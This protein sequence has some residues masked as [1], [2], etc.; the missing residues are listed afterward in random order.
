MCNT[1][2]RYT[3]CVKRSLTLSGRSHQHQ[4]LHRQRSTHAPRRQCPEEYT[5]R[6][7]DVAKRTLPSFWLEQNVLLQ[8]GW[9]SCFL[10]IK[11]LFYERRQ[12]VDVIRHI[13]NSKQNVLVFRPH[14]KFPHGTQH[15]E[16]VGYMRVGRGAFQGI[17]TV[18]PVTG[19]SCAVV[20]S[21]LGIT[22]AVSPPPSTLL[23]ITGLPTVIYSAYT[24]VTNDD[25]ISQVVQSYWFI[26]DFISGE[27][28]ILFYSALS[29]VF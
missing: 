16:C 20:F 24:T 4:P 2:Q 26:N 7:L 29:I 21:N 1:Q 13:P 8:I 19:K 11:V 14:F 25:E 5:K 27:K 18:C 10:L 12:N 6:H 22:S 9:Y 17:T 15:V 23:S 3:S 28:K